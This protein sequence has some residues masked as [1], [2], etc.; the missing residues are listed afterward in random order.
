M[1]RSY[2]NLDLLLKPSSIALIGASLK[3]GSYGKHLLRMLIEG[4]FTGKIFPINP[5]YTGYKKL[6][7]FK[8]LK[9]ISSNQTETFFD[10]ISSLPIVPDHT[11]IALGAPRVENAFSDTIKCGS[12]SLTIFADT[13]AEKFQKNMQSILKDSDIELC[14]SNSM[15]FHNLVD[16]IR[17][18]PFS[19]PLDLKVGNISLIVQSGSVLG[20][21]LN[22]DR[23]LKFNYI[24]SSGSELQTT[25]SEYLNWTINQPSTKVVGLFL[26]AIRNPEGFISALN[27]ASSKNI[28]IVILKVGKTETSS[29]FALSHT[30]AMIG[31]YEVFKTVVEENGGHLVDTIDEMA[32]CLQIFSHYTK[33][34]SGKGIASIHDSGGERELIVDLAEEVSVPYGKISKE[35]KEKISAELEPTMKPEN[36]LDAWGSGHNANKLFGNSFIYLMEDSSVSL[37]LYVMDWRQD[38]YLHLMHEKVLYTILPKIKK[39]VIAVSNYSLT[40]DH[41]LA[42]RLNENG[43]PLVKGTK[44]ALVAIKKLLNNKK[45]KARAKFNNKKTNKKFWVQKFTSSNKV[46]I[47]DNYSL[48]SEYKIN[49]PLMEMVSSFKEAKSF[50]NKTKFP[51]VLKT[52][53]ESILHKTE[54]NGVFT[55]IKTFKQ[56]S[57]V[58]KDLSNR[59]GR[60]VLIS[61]MIPEGVELS[62]GL[63][64][65]IDFGPAVVVSA[66]GTLIELIDD[67]LIFMAPI[68]AKDVKSKIHELKISKLL[69]GFRG[70]NKLDINLLCQTISN[71]SHLAWDFKDIF[72]EIDLNPVKVNANGVYA[73]DSLF[74]LK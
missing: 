10:H 72:S 57:E 54:V 6:E 66:G 11:V 31:N 45:F 15:G 58:Y 71:F 7:I 48:L 56:L 49:F 28:P 62:L 37:G 5:K 69:L 53:N 3:E 2:I 35:T 20:A 74:I 25:A 42:I 55:N 8:E 51:I 43:I 59:L 26:E 22:N 18:T 63:I 70:K 38:Y 14:G 21:L 46:S 12:K 36:P 24:I 44:E 30:G 73:L 4:G 50:L 47:K 1:K 17:I 41:E 29:K 61:E 32:A 65:D 9:I 27:L 60:E 34:K 40:N 52:A 23:R 64:N 19:F 39:P 16:G 67:K 13:S 33:V 68:S